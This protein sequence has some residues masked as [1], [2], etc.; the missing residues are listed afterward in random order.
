LVLE[1]ALKEG[2][3]RSAA[4]AVLGVGSIAYPR[5]IPSVLDEHVL[6]ATS[7]ADQRDIPL[8]GFSHHSVRRL[9]IAVWTAGPNDDCRSRDCDPRSVLNRIRGHYPDVQGN[10]SMLRRMS[11]RGEGRTMKSVIGRQ[12]YQHG[13][14]DGAHR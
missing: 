11:E 8:A 2:D 7:S 9:W 13:D 10:P 5:Q 4:R 12:I 3:Y 14:D 6:K 1:R